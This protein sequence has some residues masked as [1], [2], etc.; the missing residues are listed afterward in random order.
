MWK[1]FDISSYK[2]IKSNSYSLKVSKVI[3]SGCKDR[4]MRIIE[5]VAITQFLWVDCNSI[6][7]NNFFI[8][9]ILKFKF[10]HSPI[11]ELV[12]RCTVRRLYQCDVCTGP[13]FV[14]VRRLYWFDVCTS[15]TSVLVRRLHCLMFV[16]LRFVP[17]DVCG[18]NVRTA[19]TDYK[20]SN[21]I[22]CFIL[23]TDRCFASIS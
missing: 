16:S 22:W 3:P 18:S 15:A 23:E 8:K 13:T 7:G 17:S 5:L 14:P 12:W 20:Y 1:S 4:V 6:E 9:K 11:F 21:W 2:S 10:F 19:G